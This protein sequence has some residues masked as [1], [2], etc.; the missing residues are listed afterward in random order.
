[1]K[2]FKILFVIFG[3]LFLIVLG[4]DSCF[5]MAMKPKKR[6]PA[7]TETPISAETPAST[8]TVAST[9]PLANTLNEPIA[10]NLP[11]DPMQE[12]RITAED[13]L[14]IKVFEEPDLTTT[15]RVA[16]N[17]EITYP[18]LGTLSVGGM[19]VSEFQ[20]KITEL[21]AEDYL[22]DPQVQI[23]I[24]TYH[25]RNVSVTG[26]VSRPG[27]YPLPEGK[28]MTLMEAIT[29]AGGFTEDAAINSARIFRVE[30][31]LPKTVNVKAKDIIKK[32]DRSRDVEIFANDVVFIP[33]RMI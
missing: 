29:M 21:L 10:T 18:L 26:A 9:E 1:M 6:I 2:K 32:G 19:T 7:K 28:N 30:N 12:Y 3:L 25:S 27:S 8:E 11:V 13:V 31:G 5:A 4:A 14:Q 23:F 22:I 24:E 33:E 17:G 20:G 16:S 15:V